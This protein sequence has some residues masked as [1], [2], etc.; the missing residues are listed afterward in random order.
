MA[1]ALWKQQPPENVEAVAAAI[2][3]VGNITP[4]FQGTCLPGHLLQ[5]PR[6]Y[7]VLARFWSPQESRSEPGKDSSPYHLSWCSL[8][9]QKLS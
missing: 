7:R 6:V 4:A 3:R 2:S 1:R 8:L 5:T 9:L